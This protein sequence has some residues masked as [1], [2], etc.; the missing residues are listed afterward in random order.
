M[1]GTIKERFESKF[2]KTEGCWEW[3][4]GK[5]KLGYGTFRLGDRTLL[6]H[7]ASYQLYIEDVPENMCVCHHCCNP[8][9][10]NPSHLFLNA[11]PEYIK[12]DTIERFESKF[13]K[14]DGCWEWQSTKVPTGYGYFMLDRKMRSAHRLAYRF[15]VGE[16]P[17]GMCVCHHC[18]NPG[19]VNPDHLFLGTM[20][21]NMADCKRKG[22]GR[23]GNICGEDQWNAKLT[24]AQ[25]AEIREKSR[26]GVRNYVLAKE[27]EVSNQTISRIVNRITW[28]HI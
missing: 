18:D 17:E 6:A 10:V 24:N 3:I 15:Y 11:R 9:C 25:V 2:T 5:N 16:I 22:R 1:M 21:D 8:S 20:A 4:A 12:Q 19:C 28:K 7:R 26:N 27:Y 14:S 13:N 23:G